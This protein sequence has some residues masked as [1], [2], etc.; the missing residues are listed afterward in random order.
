[1]SLENFSFYPGATVASAKMGKRSCGV[2]F[3]EGV[4]TQSKR[5]I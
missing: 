4:K 2:E 5:R 3:F 1:M